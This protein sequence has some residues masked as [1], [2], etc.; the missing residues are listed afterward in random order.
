MLQHDE[1]GHLLHRIDVGALDVALVHADLAEVER[2]VAGRSG[3][4]P[5]VLDAG[6]IG[7]LVDGEEPERADLAAC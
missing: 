4:T 1:L 2:R 6:Q 5:R 7:L 3:T